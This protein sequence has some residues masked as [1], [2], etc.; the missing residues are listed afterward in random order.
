MVNKEDKKKAAV[1]SGII[2]TAVGLMKWSLDALESGEI[3]SGIIGLVISMM[4]VYGH[5]MGY[6]RH[7][8]VKVSTLTGVVET[9]SE[10]IE[11]SVDND[12][13]GMSN[14]TEDG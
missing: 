9:I 8:D 12:E 1:G 3:V 14:E 7:V 11:E 4:I 13:G 2:V 6:L 5:H 10:E